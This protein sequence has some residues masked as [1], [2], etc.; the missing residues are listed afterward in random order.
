MRPAGG[1]GG[2]GGSKQ[3][4]LRPEGESPP[5]RY[6]YWVLEPLLALARANLFGKTALPGCL[7]G[8]R[9][10]RPKGRLP[11]TGQRHLVALARAELFGR[12]P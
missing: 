12:Q 5:L 7:Y 4:R 6:R 3:D 11:K 2:P 8:A 1:V 10:R 9:V